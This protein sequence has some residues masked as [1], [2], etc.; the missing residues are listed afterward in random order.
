[1]HN[2]MK[3]KVYIAPELQVLELELRHQM[4]AGSS[5]TVNFTVSD[6]EVDEGFADAREGLRWYDDEGRTNVWR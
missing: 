4:M 6:D 2:V 5:D 1:M 3:K